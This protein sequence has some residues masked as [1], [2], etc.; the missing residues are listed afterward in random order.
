[1][2]FL[3]FLF[4]VCFFW[5]VLLSGSVDNQRFTIPEA[6]SQEINHDGCRSLPI[7]LVG[8]GSGT[9]IVLWRWRVND[10]QGCPKNNNIKNFQF[11]KALQKPLEFMGVQGRYI[12]WA[13]GAIGGA[14]VGY[15]APQN[16]DKNKG[17][18][19]GLSL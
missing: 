13:A 9:S 11:S 5:C 18:G 16:L 12:Y 8:C 15:N 17:G 4:P 10:K 1:L 3:K 19:K 2:E 14:I 6:D 7:F